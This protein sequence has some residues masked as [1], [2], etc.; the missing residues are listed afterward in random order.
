MNNKEL[1]FDIP[2][3]LIKAFAENPRVVLKTHPDGLWP[4]DFKVLP[5]LERMLKDKE[6]KE[7]FEIV[8]MPRR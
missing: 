8:I 2:P 4:V 1:R 5:L 7:N 6:F 3:V